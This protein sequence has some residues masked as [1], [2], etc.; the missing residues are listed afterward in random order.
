[1]QFT[2]QVTNTGT[3]VQL[4]F[5]NAQFFFCLDTELRPSDI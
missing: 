5:A 1:M 2:G 4:T 3:H